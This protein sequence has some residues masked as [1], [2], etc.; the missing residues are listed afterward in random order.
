VLT[1]WA[2]HKAVVVLESCCEAG[3]RD[4]YGLEEETNIFLYLDAKVDIA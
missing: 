4:K 2:F 1:E 3:N